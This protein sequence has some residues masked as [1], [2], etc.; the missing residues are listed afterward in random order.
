V[1][2]FL[3]ISFLTIEAIFDDFPCT[4]LSLVTMSTLHEFTSLAL[5]K[6]Y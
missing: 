2:R 4:R 5:I 1:T 3:T 6:S